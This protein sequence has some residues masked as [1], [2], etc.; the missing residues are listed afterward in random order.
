M[1]ITTLEATR[2]VKHYIR[3]TGI[4]TDEAIRRLCEALVEEGI[5]QTILGSF[6]LEEIRTDVR[7][8]NEPQWFGSSKQWSLDRNLSVK[9][10]QQKLGAEVTNL[11]VSGDGKVKNEWRFTVDGKKC[12]IWDYKGARWSAFGP[13][14][15]FEK[16][17]L[18]V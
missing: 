10:I 8:K 9:D 11:G 4:S 2:H 14:E 13:K 16:L 6:E 7:V 5:G 18:D 1:N 12:A 17:G 3:Q 15:A